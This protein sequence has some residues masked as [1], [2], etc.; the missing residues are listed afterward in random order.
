MKS[1]DGEVVPLS[2]P[3]VIETNVESWLGKLSSEMKNTL[4]QLLDNCIK[5]CIYSNAT[6]ARLRL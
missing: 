4:Q 5:V 3:V 1:Q 6:S 2:Q